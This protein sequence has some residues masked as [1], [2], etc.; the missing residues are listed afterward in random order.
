MPVI[1]ILF[2]LFMGDYILTYIG[3]SLGAVQ[4]VNIFLI[5]LVNLPLAIGII[6]RL[7]MFAIII[8]VPIYFIKK[9]KIR[10]LLSKIFY[11]VAF[12]ANIGVLFLH[13]Y[14][15]LMYRGII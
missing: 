2:I 12:T 1:L 10:P 5:W 8:C 4:E 11:G 7:L 13:L 15:I 9:N 3:I 14:W 6:A